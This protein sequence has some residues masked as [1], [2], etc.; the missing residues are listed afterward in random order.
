MGGGGETTQNTVTTPWTGQ[1]PYLKQAFSEAQNIYNANKNTLNPG[2]QG[3]Y[4][5]GARPEQVDSFKNA[6]N[7]TTGAGN[8]GNALGM[9]V[10]QDAALGGAG[11]VGGATSGLFNFANSDPTQHNIDAA[12]K[13]AD[14]GFLNGQINAALRDPTRQLTEQTLPGINRGAAGTGNL[15]SSR[16]GVAEGIAQRGYADRAADVSAQ[17]RGDAYQNGLQT[18]QGD[19]TARLG[20]LTTAGNLGQGALSTGL[21]GI[22]NSIDS[23]A[24]MNDMATVA[25]SML[26]SSDQSAIDNDLAKY[27]AMLSQPYQNLEQYWNIVGD[28]S[29]GGQSSST[30]KTQPSAMSTIGSGLG[31]LGALFRC[32]RRVKANIYQI[33][34]FDNGLPK[35]IFSYRDDPTSQRFIGPMAQDVEQRFPDLVVEIGG[36]KHVHMDALTKEA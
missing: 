28:K 4:V 22:G 19:T 25:G 3:D 21:Q 36:V 5:A 24:K 18:A 17:M 7:Y 11:A 30:T 23:Q 33:G 6:L 27:N 26:Q 32:D 15:N 31:I 34:S 29:W 12:G 14:N 8:D 10:S 13:Y 1:Q 2:Y 35:Y 20:A 9:D 16:T